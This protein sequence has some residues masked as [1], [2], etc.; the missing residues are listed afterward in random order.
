MPAPLPGRPA[1][2]R[3]RRWPAYAWAAPASLIGLG[4]AL[5]WR[6]LGGRSQ[7]VDGVLEVGGGRVPHL[8][9]R[10][11]RACRFEAITLGHVIL[12]T[13]RRTLARLRP[14][15]QVHVRQ[16]ERWGLLFFPLYGAASLLALLRGRDPYRDNR[17]EREAFAAERAERP[18][19]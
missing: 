5:G 11:P 16:Y 13:D 14:H 2:I 4:A 15:E 7:V 6:L 10:L 18:P 19:R 17:F 1:A 8:V 3:P 12:G 9:A